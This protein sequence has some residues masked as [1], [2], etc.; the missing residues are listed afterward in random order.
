MGLIGRFTDSLVNVV[1]NLGTGRD[2]SAHNQ[3][4][5]EFLSPIELLQTYRTSWLAK[6]I[7]DYPAEDSTRKWR[8]WRAD[9]EQITKIEAEEKRLRLQERVQGALIASR[10]F[11]GSAIYI[12]VADRDQDQPLVPG[13]EI[14][15]LVVLPRVSLTPGPVIR[16]I[17]SRYYGKP[18]R[19]MVS[20]GADS[21]QVWIHASRL[22]IF[23]GEEIPGGIDMANINQGWGDSILQST[24]EAVKQVDSTMANM[25]SLVFEAKVDV[26]KFE[27]FADLMAEEP[28]EAVVTRRLQ[29]QAAMKGI[30]GA[31]VIDTKDDYQQKNASF[32]GLHE[33]VSK[34]M[35]SV[36]GAARI[37]LT[38]IYGRATVG[39]SGSGDGD[40]RIYFDR[41]SHMQ[42]TVIGPALGLLDECIIIQA[43]GSRPPEVYYQWAPLRQLTESER[44][45]IFVKTANAARSLAGTT[46][47]TLIPLD[48]LSDSLV[49]ELVEQG[50]LPGL[51]QSIEKYGSLSEQELPPEAVT[52]ASTIID[53]APRPLYV[54]RKVLNAKEILAHYAAQGIENLIGAADMHVT[55]TYSRNP[56]SWMAM[57]DSW[58][59]E[60]VV[61]AG[62]ARIMEA[63]GEN[64]DTAVLSFA[65]SDLKWR[66]D[67][68]VE[69]GASW[70]WPD[71]QPHLSI[72]Y[73]FAGDID[74][75]KPWAGEIKFGPEIF[76]ALNE[77]WKDE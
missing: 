16:D 32:G 42:G 12:N 64:K 18:D 3:Y 20:S 14:Q 37:P 58:A 48:A 75:I 13:V 24:I 77:N 76:E 61:Q 71:Y 21:A 11:G 31:V 27:G 51:E 19:Y 70:D 35:D 41:I 49:N 45:E 53:A 69:Q 62:G 74:S 57:G 29:A 60:L 55:I 7:V 10:L 6:A 67:A 44:A 46:A 15:S 28:S 26:F 47:G 52:S 43:L 17:G 56:V 1:A 38:R 59:S 30:N 23:S 68:M 65:S 33:V 25:A 39:L 54:S 50:V 8:D 2:K 4:V 9:A 22:V 5:A 66:H 34:F 36:A 73:D 40:E 63:F 72:S